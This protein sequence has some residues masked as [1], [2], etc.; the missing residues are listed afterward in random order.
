M[1]RFDNSRCCVEV[2][3]VVIG[4]SVTEEDP[5]EVV[6]IQLA[7]PRARLFDTDAQTKI[8]EVGE[9]RFL[10]VQT[11]VRHLVLAECTS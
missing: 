6:L 9:V 4:G 3:N 8:F 5:C 7:M 1:A 2:D 10:T 11:L